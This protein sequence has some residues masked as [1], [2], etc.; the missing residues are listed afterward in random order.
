MTHTLHRLGST[1]SLKDDYIVLIVR[2]REIK[3]EPFTHKPMPSSGASRFLKRMI[4]EF[5][6]RNPNVRSNVRKTLLSVPNVPKFPGVL[7]ELE[8]SL[9]RAVVPPLTIFKNKADLISFLKWLRNVNIGSSVV[10]SGLF[11]E[12]DDCL[13]MIGMRPHTV[14]FS[15][16]IFGKRELLPREEV[17]QITTMCGHHMISPRLVEKLHHDIKKDRITCEKA[18]RIMGKQCVCRAFNMDRAVRL[19]KGLSTEK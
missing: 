3:R 18:A 4:S 15:L 12:V 9:I 1:E 7:G 5:S 6:K 2:S 10:V 8:K 16:G 19:L 11:S 14:E 13:K 17:L